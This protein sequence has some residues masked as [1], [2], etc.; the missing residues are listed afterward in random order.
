[1]IKVSYL[2][3]AKIKD[4]SLIN[5]I[6]E[7][8]PQFIKEK[9]DNINNEKKKRETLCAWYLLYK[10]L[11]SL[12]L[13]IKDYEFFTPVNKKPYVKD[14]PFYFNLSHSK[15]LCACVVASFP[16][17]IDVEYVKEYSK[18]IKDAYFSKE[19]KELMLNSDN[20]NDTFFKIWTLKESYVK[21]KSLGLFNIKDINVLSLEPLVTNAKDDIS[22]N[23]F[24]IGNYKLSLCVNG[25]E[26][27]FNIEKTSI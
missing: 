24:D 15:G 21:M 6:Y 5:G 9:I 13:D 18:K 17:G 26:E 3:F 14:N 1:M 8:L 16:C 20:K 4:K 2:D 27:T 12:S 7:N 25:K 19:E 11:C 23:T 10:T 22:F